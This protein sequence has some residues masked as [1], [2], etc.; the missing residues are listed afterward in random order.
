MQE[1]DDLRERVLRAIHAGTDGEAA[2][3]VVR[4]LQESIQDTVIGPI[5]RNDADVAEATQ[6][7][8]LAILKSVKNFRGESG[9]RTWAHIIA[10]RVAWRR[11]RR[12]KKRKEEPL[13]SSS[14]RLPEP[15]RKHVSEGS[16]TWA[17]NRE[18]RASLEKITERL[19]P[20]DS[21]LLGLLVA[22]WPAAEIQ[23]QLG[24]TAVALRQRQV[25]LNK[26]IALLA[27]E[28]GVAL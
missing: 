13:E 9:V 24:V 27:R 4:A 1:A 19:S 8:A 25:R 10:R 23:E 3:L 14:S 18:R 26:R 21:E 17:R 16:A 28:L 2:E 22:D 12:G 7:W 15:L 11:L 20:A 5:L 6:D